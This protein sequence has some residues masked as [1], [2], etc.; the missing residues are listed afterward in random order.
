LEPH[1]CLMVGQATYELPL[2]VKVKQ[3]DVKA[4]GETR[5]CFA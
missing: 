3:L 4:M 5:R 1:H 2:V